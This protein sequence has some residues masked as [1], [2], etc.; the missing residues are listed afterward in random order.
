MT[1]ELD[2]VD[3]VR[4][5]HQLLRIKEYLSEG[6]MDKCS[7]LRGLAHALQILLFS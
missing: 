2:A 1:S 3:A 5:E 4:V 7:L 6:H